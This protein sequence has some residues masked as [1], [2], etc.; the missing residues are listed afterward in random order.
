MDYLSAKRGFAEGITAQA[1]AWT[2]APQIGGLRIIMDLPALMIVSLITYIIFIGIKESRS[3][4]N[5]M[6]ILKLAVIFFVI[7]LGAYYVNPG[8]WSPLTPTGFSAIMKGV[9]AVFFAYIGF[10]AISTTAE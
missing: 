9:S 2:N 8:N 1:A 6:V 3:A 10:D 7:V 5:I 4:S